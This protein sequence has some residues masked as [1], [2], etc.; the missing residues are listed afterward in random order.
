MKIIIPSLGRAGTSPTAKWIVQSKRPV[1]F[2]VHENEREAYK[3]AYPW[4]FIHSVPDEYKHHDGKLR[5]YLLDCSSEPY[6]SVDDDV[7][8][9][10]KTFSN[11]DY[12]FDQLE[13]HINC[14]ATMAGIGQQLFS[15]A[16]KISTI[17]DDPLAVR[18]KFASL[19]YAI[20]PK[21]YIDCGLPRLRIYGDIALVIHA[22]Q[23][24]GGSIVSYSAT[25]TNASPPQGGCNSWR[26][27]EIILDDLK[28]ICEMYPDICTIR[29]TSATTH[30]QYIGVG[31]RVAWSKIK[32]L[33]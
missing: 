25:H 22:I 5:K 4:C 17:N 27:K 31:L 18:N 7:R 29:E 8:I 9:S 14:G 10:L 32:K 21:P 26:T 20:N 6:F 19:V 16:A 33:S 30:S 1:Y 24:G 13:H 28:A 15:N 12:V 2:A 23:Y 3:R 11:I